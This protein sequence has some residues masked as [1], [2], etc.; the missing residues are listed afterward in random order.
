MEQTEEMQSQVQCPSNPI[1]LTLTLVAASA[2]ALTCREGVVGAVA[3]GQ[4]DQ[5]ALPRT[6]EPPLHT[7]S[8]WVTLA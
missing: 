7:K 8:E 2:T 6:D 4:V 1:Y 3:A 5:H